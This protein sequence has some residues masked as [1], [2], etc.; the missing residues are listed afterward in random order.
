MNRLELNIHKFL[1]GSPKTRNFIKLAYQSLLYFIPRKNTASFTID[2]KHGYFFGFHTVS[3]WSYNNKYL[4]THHFSEINRERQSGKGH[5]ITIGVFYG[6]RFEHFKPLAVS[7]AYNWQQGAMAQ[8]LGSNEVI[9]FND[10]ISNSACAKLVDIEGKLLSTFKY[11]VAS[12]SPLGDK[13]ISYSYNCLGKGMPGYGYDN[14]TDNDDSGKLLE[15]DIETGA[16]RTLINVNELIELNYTDI[17]KSFKDYFHFI[18]HCIYSPTGSNLTFFL[19]ARGKSTDLSTFVYCVCL[20]YGHV[21]KLPL[22]EYI[23]HYS[24][25]SDEELILY[26]DDLSGRRG[27]H[28]VNVTE[29]KVY[30]LNLT[31][32]EN[33]LGDGHPQVFHGTE[34][35][36]TDTY[37]DR[38][39]VQRL[40]KSNCRTGDTREIV[41]FKIPY[42]FRDEY[43]CD[44]HPRWDRSGKMISFDSAHEGTRSHCIL[45]LE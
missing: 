34:N 8:W 18:S 6:E 2:V 32:S 30:K 5:K 28:I 1:E 17:E 20:K 27:Y 3:P 22:G 37:P 40:Y 26:C 10:I 29:S 41:A 25:I 19:R 38:F 4:L 33:P 7:S 9:I 39:R 12:T 42:K 13:Y 35:F 45:Y 16:A 14:I 44:F 31:G 23:S 21:K 15:V 24:W 11:P 36:V 43:R